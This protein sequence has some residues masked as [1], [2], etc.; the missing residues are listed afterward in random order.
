[1]KKINVPSLNDASYVGLSIYNCCIC[2]VV[3]MPLSLFNTQE[4]GVTYAIVGG[5]MVFCTTVSLCMLFIPKII[6]L[7]S[8]DPNAAINGVRIGTTDTKTANS[9][10][11]IM[12]IQ[13]TANI[14]QSV[15]KDTNNHMTVPPV[16]EEVVDNANESKA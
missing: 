8:K 11:T 2:A 15:G 9:G 6:A 10:S 12:T 7:R 1:M 13:T 14:S 16:S 3:A 5:L 4:I